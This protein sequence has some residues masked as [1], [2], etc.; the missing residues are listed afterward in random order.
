MNLQTLPK[1]SCLMRA[2]NWDTYAPNAIKYFLQQD[3][4]NKELV[5]FDSSNGVGYYKLKETGLFNDE[6]IVYVRLKFNRPK[7][8]IAFYKQLG[9]KRKIC[10]SLATGE[11]LITWNDDDI[12]FPDRIT[13]SVN[14]I[15]GFDAATIN[16]AYFYFN[17][18]YYLYPM[19]IHNKYYFHEVSAIYKASL[20]K[21][22]DRD[23]NYHLMQHSFKN[24]PVGNIGKNDIFVARV[25]EDSSNCLNTK[26]IIDNLK[27]IGPT[28][29]N[30]RI[31]I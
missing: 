27:S 7:N 29:F 8:R 30:R 16:D 14:A 17:G 19:G 18:E 31:I 5:I 26:K 15:Q 2:Y 9:E 6:R 13:E 23:N 28:K 22:I 25:R 1:V 3:Y 24:V 10:E 12:S 21:R 4:K 11:Y 20:I